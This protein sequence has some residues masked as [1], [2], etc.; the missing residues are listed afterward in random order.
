M[1]GQTLKVVGKTND[2]LKEVSA[3]TPTSSPAPAEAPK[4][5]AGK[6]CRT[7][8]LKELVS[9]RELQDDD[10]FADVATDIEVECALLSEDRIVS[11]WIPR[12]E[13]GRD[14]PG[15]G[16]AFVRFDSVVGAS[17]CRRLMSGRSYAG[18]EFEVD[19]FSDAKFDA[20]DFAALV[21][22]QD[23]P[24]KPPPTPRDD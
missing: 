4:K 15:V 16:S 11:I 7:L 8:M 10:D 1:Q 3:Q 19:F 2:G 13:R 6:P 21:P 20:T 23:V 17:T 14:V 22:N 18:Q 9:K 5:L 12:P 24:A